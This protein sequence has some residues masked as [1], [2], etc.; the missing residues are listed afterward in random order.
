[1]GAKQVYLVTDENFIQAAT[2]ATSICDALKKMKLCSR[3]ANYLIFRKRA[4]VLKLELEY[5]TEQ[6]YNKYKTI[7]SQID[8]EQIILAC[9]Q[10]KSRKK[11]T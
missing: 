10:N 1:M 3:G 2:T 8:D 5:M 6:S 4:E 9:K 11:N 7:R